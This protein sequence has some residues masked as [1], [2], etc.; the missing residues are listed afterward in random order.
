MSKKLLFS[1]GILLLILISCS[2]Q[3][4]GFRKTY[5]V[6]RPS[7]HISEKEKG[8]Q[9]PI[10]TEIPEEAFVTQSDSAHIGDETGKLPEPMYHTDASVHK[11][12]IPFS[13]DHL[14][15]EQQHTNNNPEGR[16]T[17]DTSISIAINSLLFCFL[18]ILAFFLAVIESSYIGLAFVLL[19]AA[20]AVVLGIVTLSTHSKGKGIAI[21]SII[22]GA[23]MF[24]IALLLL[25]TELAAY[26]A[27]S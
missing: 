12:I 16:K 15:P 23:A 5:P 7:A 9:A 4:F 18:A 8:E 6:D 24:F 2:Q 1:G 21:A 26:T 25:I 17:E 27:R 22:L 14:S 10:A 11:N 13:L 19:L 3:R 20:A